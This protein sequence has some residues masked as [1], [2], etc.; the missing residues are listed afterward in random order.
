M[1]SIQELKA[2]ARRLPLA[3]FE[4]QMG[5]FALI[6]RPPEA[7]ASQQALKLGANRTQV[8]RRDPGGSSALSLILDFED[9]MIATLPP[10][11]AVDELVVGRLPDSDLVI[12]DASVSKRHALLRWDAAKKGCWVKDLGSTNGTLV[13]Q[14]PLPADHPTPLFDGTVLSFGDVDFWFLSSATLH[15]KLVRSVSGGRHFT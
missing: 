9:L 12:D 3:R 4:Q 5:P 6:Q 1:L 13:N 14:E 8:Q 11:R 10:V 7:V 15:E 2:L